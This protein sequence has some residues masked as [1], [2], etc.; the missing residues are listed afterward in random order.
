MKFLALT[1]LMT[2]SGPSFATSSF[3]SVR[4]VLFSAA[5][6]TDSKV[7]SEMKAYEQGRLPHY[8]VSA[9][10][11]VVGGVNR[12]LERATHTLKDTDDFYPRLE[13][14]VHSNG[15]CFTGV[16][17]I[18]ETNPYSGYFKPGSTGL[19]VGRASTAL[20]ETERGDPRGFGFAGKIF[21][22]LDPNA[23]V[24]TANFF[25]VDILI[26][27]QRDRYLDV[28]MTNNPDTGFRV[29]VVSMALKIMKAFK[30]VDTDPTYRPLYPISELGLVDGEK[31]KTPKFMM[32]TA[33]KSVARN[34]DTDFR[35]EV[36][37]K[38]NHANGIKFNILVNDTSKAQDAAEWKKIG[39][40]EVNESTVS[41]GCDRQLH[42]AHPKMR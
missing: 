35:D 1:F 12:L 32:I 9:T 31:V 26:G 42:F 5:K 7:E 20:S 24:K 40:I 30:A 39:N 11:F 28:K 17:K 19:F 3:N 10:N 25:L 2:L 8:E 41:Y 36:S 4:D 29:S 21:P 16:W 23:M 13:K 15:A 22:T 18:T 6:T 14:L 37:I 33:D 27:T 34:D 38:K